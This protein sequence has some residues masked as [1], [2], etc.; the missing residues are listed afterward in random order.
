LP[1]SDDEYDDVLA[2]LYDAGAGR[3]DWRQAFEALAERYTLWSI[4]LFVIARDSRD[5]LLI[6]EGG[7][8]G[9]EFAL[10]Y[11]R[12]YHR[13]DPHIGPSLAL[14]CA[15][16]HWLHGRH[17]F[18]DDFVARDPFYQEFLL[19]R[20]GR[21]TSCAKLFEDQDK[22]GL[23]LI[24]RGKGQPPLADADIALFDRLRRHLAC[25]VQLHLERL[26][27]LT[28]ELGD[29]H[30]ILDRMREALLITDAD[31]RIVYQSP[32][33]QRLIARANT[34]ST[35]NGRLVCRNREDESGLRTVVGALAAGIAPAAGED[36]ESAV[37]RIVGSGFINPVMVLATGLPA[38]GPGPGKP[39][40]ADATRAPNENGLAMLL[41]HETA[42]RRH[43]DPAVIGMVFQLTPAEAEV[44]TGLAEGL[45]IDEIAAARG[46]TL[47]TIR[48]Q[49]RSVYGK[50][51]VRS[52]ADLVRMLLEM[53]SFDDPRALPDRSR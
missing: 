47:E 46:V 40:R 7:L 37:I 50:T 36:P 25:A 22:A 45:P 24:Q 34:F 19:P 18:D 48:A 2:R 38:S 49:I 21:H 14:A 6:C 32:A 42:R 13:I 39:P 16:G 44:A 17:H 30:R 11:L 4:A 26:G 3:I 15:P 1:I 12:I 41:L 20:G 51:G 52:R 33:A 9:P 8:S 29:P 28:T 31:L 43:V 5:A 53:P 27:R 10:E 35:R 23:L